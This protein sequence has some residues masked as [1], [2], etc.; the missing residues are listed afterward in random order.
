MRLCVYIGLIEKEVKPGMNSFKKARLVA[1]YT[2]AQ[3]ARLVGVSC[4]SV[5]QWENG[6]NLPN[7]NRLHELAE[8]LGTSVEKLLEEKAG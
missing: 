2:Q 6:K 5:S 3:L 4:V 7:V 8:I 1:G